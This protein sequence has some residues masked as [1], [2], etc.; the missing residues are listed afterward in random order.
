VV[1]ASGACRLSFAWRY[2]LRA[3]LI[4]PTEMHASGLVASVGVVRSR[5]LVAGTKPKRPR[6]PH[7]RFFSQ[8]KSRRCALER[9]AYARFFDG[10]RT[11]NYLVDQVS[12][13][14]SAARRKAESLMPS[15]PPKI[16]AS[17]LKQELEQARQAMAA[18]TERLRD[19]RLAKEA[20]EK[21]VGPIPVQKQKQQKPRIKRARNG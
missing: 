16:A 6:F 18:K 10:E 15:R 19:L 21:A 17:A 9:P 12:S 2:S 3:K 4:V 5:S 8:P 11:M 1:T 13:R 20:A 7:G 14:M